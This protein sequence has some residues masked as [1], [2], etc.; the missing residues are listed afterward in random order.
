MKSYVITIMENEKS[1]AAARRCMN[2]AGHFGYNVEEFHAFSP[3]NCDIHQLFKDE[4]LSIEGFKERYSR[5]DNCLCA[6]FSHY[7][8]WKKCLEDKQEYMIFEHD[9]VMVDRVQPVLNYKGCI[10]LGKPSYGK[11]NTPESLGVNPLVSKPYF[12][13]AHAYRLK[14]LGA[15]AL[16]N[17][18]TLDARPTDVYLDVR[19]FPFLEEYYPWPVDAQDWFTTIQNE[20]GCIAKHN[21]REGYEII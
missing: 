17:V 11:Y 10:S 8:L 6:F 16:I 12:P 21:Y 9:A 3:Q 15:E 7:S 13:G 4:G 18:A 2:S 1:K 14:P 5:L 20:T 19:R